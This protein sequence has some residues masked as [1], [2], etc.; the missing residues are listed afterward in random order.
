M[1]YK[2]EDLREK[3]ALTKDQK[4]FDAIYSNRRNMTQMPPIRNILGYRYD[5]MLLPLFRQ[6]ESFGT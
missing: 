3:K 5:L 1:A 4:S 2:R 6:T